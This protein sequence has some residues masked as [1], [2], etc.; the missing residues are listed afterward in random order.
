MGLFPKS[1]SR[2]F[3]LAGIPLSKGSKVFIVDAVHGSD[4]NTGL[5]F[6]DPLLTVAA[7]LALT[8]TLHNDVVLLVGNGT[9]YAEAAID[10]HHDF[11]HLIGLNSGGPEPRSRIKCTAAL[12]TTPFFTVSGDGCIIRNVSFWH[13]TTDAAGLVNVLASGSRNLFEGCQFAGGMGTNNSAGA[14]SLKVGAA[15]EGSGNT[16]RN[17]WI[18]CDTI[19]YVTDNVPLEFVSGAMHT[20]FEDCVFAITAGATTN[21]HVYAAAAAG[22]GRLNQF[23]RCL[24][25]NEDPATVQASVFGLGAALSPSSRIIMLDCWQYGVAKWDSNNRGVVSN[26]TIAANTTGVNTGNTLIITSA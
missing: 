17:C 5:T 19:A 13:E 10:W 26:N 25:V 7:A 15:G 16:F 24:F 3:A 20:V 11:T 1:L 9:S 6:E 12:A 23:K 2:Y 4:S 18:G 8:T 21:V 14:R 22:V